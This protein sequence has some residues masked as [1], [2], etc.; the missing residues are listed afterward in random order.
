MQRKYMSLTLMRRTA[1]EAVLQQ[2][3]DGQLHV[4]R[5]VCCALP[6]VERCNCI[7]HKELIGMV[8][9]LKKY[10]QHLLGRPIIVRTD[11]TALTYF[12]KT[13]APIGHQGR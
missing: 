9:G 5:Y 10:R 8:I 3:Q 6:H 11:H 4:I 2:E 13:P 1:L 12:M 7:T